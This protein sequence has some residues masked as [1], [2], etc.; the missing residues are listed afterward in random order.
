MMPYRSKIL[1][2][3]SNYIVNLVT[4][5]KFFNSSTFVKEV[6]ITLISWGVDRRADLGSSSIIEAGTGY[7]IEKL[8]KGYKSYSVTKGSKLKVRKFWGL[9]PRLQGKIWLNRGEGG[10]FCSVISNENNKQTM[11]LVTWECFENILSFTTKLNPSLDKSI[12]CSLFNSCQ[13][14]IYEEDLKKM[15]HNW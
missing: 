8:Q 12:F 4:W 14:Q 13:V 2:C 6:F 15:F 9:S 3:G 10:F 1:S 5:P 7:G 11:N